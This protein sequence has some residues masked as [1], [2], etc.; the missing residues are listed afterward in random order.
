VIAAG[1][2]DSGSTG[3]DIWIRKHDPTGA[4]LWISLVNGPA[5][6]EDFARAVAV[7]PDNTIVVAGFVTGDA[8][9]G[10]EIW[11][12]K[13]DPSGG[14]VW[15]DTVAGPYETGDDSAY[16]VTVLDD[17]SVIVGGE[18]TL[19]SQDN[20]LWV[21]KYDAG[22]NEQWTYTHAG[23]GLALDSARGL[24]G[25]ADGDVYVTGWDTAS[26]GGRRIWTAKLAGANGAE[27]WAQ[28]YTGGAVNGNTGFG[29]G[30]LSDSSLAVTGQQRTGSSTV[31]AWTRSYDANG[32]EGWTD[33]FSGLTGGAD[34]GHGIGI[35]SDDT[36]TIVG[37]F[38]N[39]GDTTNIFVRKL[40]AAGSEQWTEAIA[41][42]TKTEADGWAV[43][44]DPTNDHI[45]VAGCQADPGDVASGDVYI[46]KYTP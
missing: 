40:D 39:S 26:D 6:G 16:A 41:G 46:L 36:V 7:G 12:S 13:L 14:E 8:V 2:A 37:T 5:S 15:T 25:T 3:T 29:V 20:D 43:A 18:L 23:D 1:Y 17:G 22:G 4:E 9:S 38:L 27:T 32:G 34:I 45:V 30:T 10:R 24:S 21:R 33:V 42:D 44:I 28:T 35:G 19:T 31:D 11:V